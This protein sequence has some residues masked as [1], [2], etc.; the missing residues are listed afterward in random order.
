MLSDEHQH[1]FKTGALTSTA[2]QDN[3]KRGRRVALLSILASAILAGANMAVG[4]LAGSTSVVATGFEFLGDVLA[5]V[6]V[7][8][9]MTIASKPADAN[10]PYGHGRFETLAALFVGIILALGGAGI[11]WRSLQRISEVHAPPSTYAVV[12]LLAAIL[13]RSIMSSINSGWGAE[14]GARPWWQMRGMM[15]SIFFQRLP[16]L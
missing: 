10:H 12:P 15:R 16:L 6:T 4:L 2:H 1:P 3:F 13:I 5:S 8:V 9:G 11:C 7:L 14:L